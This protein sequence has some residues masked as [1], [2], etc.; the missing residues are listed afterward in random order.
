MKHWPINTQLLISAMCFSFLV[1]N[2]YASPVKTSI[3]A[4]DVLITTNPI[5]KIAIIGESKVLRPRMGGKKAV[6]SLTASKLFV[7]DSIQKLKQAFEKK[8][9]QVVFAEPA[10]IG[11]YWYGPDGYWVYD[12]DAKEG[13]LDKWRIEGTS[14]VYEYATIKNDSSLRNAARTEFERLNRY[15]ANKRFLLYDPQKQNLATIA[16]ANGADTVCFVRMFGKRYSTGREVGDAALTVLAAMFGTVRSS[17]LKEYKEVLTICSA[18]DTGQVLWQYTHSTS[19]DPLG[20]I[21]SKQLDASN[22]SE[23]TDDEFDTRE[24]PP[25]DNFFDN[26]LAKLPA[27]NHPLAGD[28]KMTDRVRMTV[29]CVEK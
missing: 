1:F 28:C 18:V 6:L 23:E 17:N 11:Y 26:A 27:Y 5:K 10:G 4:S 29:T 12:F 16:E 24:S 25:V 13:E 19:Q 15:I 21:S 22:K 3:R 2:V 9:Y 7:E 14:P 8:G 20:N